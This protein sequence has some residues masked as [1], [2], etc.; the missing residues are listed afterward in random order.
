MIAI[1]K[2][3]KVCYVKEELNSCVSQKAKNQCSGVKMKQRPAQSNNE[4][5]KNPEVCTMM[6]WAALE[7]SELIVQF[8]V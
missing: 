4:L 5:S 1:L 6:R 2:Y 7:R 8:Q 3:L